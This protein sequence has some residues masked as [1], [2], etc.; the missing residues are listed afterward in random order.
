MYQFPVDM[1][2][3]YESS[4]L[5][6][7][8]YQNI[9]GKAT[10][11]LASD[12][13]CQNTGMRRD[14]VLTWLETGMFERMHPDDVGFMSK[15]SD[16]FL[17]QRGPYDIVFRCR[18]GKDYVSIHGLGKWQTM[19]DG[20]ELA[21]I[22]YANLKQTKEGFFSIAERYEMF[23]RDKF[24]TDPLTELPNINYI[25]EYGDE[26]VNVIRAEGMT[27]TII[28]SDVNSMQSYNNRYGF[29][30]GDK[31]LQLIADSLK[32]QFPDA[33]LTRGADDHFI[34]VVGIK[35]KNDLAAKLEEAND[36]IRESASGNTSGIYS[37]ICIL[38]AGE[39]VVEGIDHAKHALKRIANDM[40]RSYRFFSREAEEEYWNNRYIIENFDRALE[41]GLIKVYYQGL[42]RVESQK[43]AAFEALAR[44]IDPVR[45]TISPGK[46]IPVLQKYHQLYKLDLYMLEQ[47]CKEIHIRHE[48]GLPMLPVSV[49]FSRQDFDHADIVGEMNALYEKYGMEKYVG[50]DY[51]IVE[52]TEQDV[53]VGA[54]TFHDQL[55]RIRANGYQL[56]LD[57][58]GSG[59]SAINM[60]SQFHFDLIKYDMELLRRLDD[61]G[62]ANRLI[63]RELVY[64]AKK[65]G[66]HTLIEGVEN[67]EQIEF[68]REIGCE[69]VQGFYYYRPESLDSQLYRIHGGQKVKPCETIEERKAYNQKWFE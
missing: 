3:S 43:I 19:P 12:G 65:L 7:V 16:D 66:I 18:I 9:D 14:K 28:Y 26:K 58:F 67:E 6:F 44:W 1:R 56:W 32:K 42:I 57:D 33:L 22:G 27:P 63:L 64:V 51:F 38:N 47:V 36:T 30:E 5:S 54:E 68:I 52:I 53:A 62:G 61:N 10:P 35:D 37:G 23:Q 11:I 49:N 15:V 34:I 50:K 60:F 40:T 59:Y 29:K 24:Y 45:G 20:T 39:T 25:H 31:L 21:V 17:H 41:D 55:K 13:F 4:P 48:N 46:F 69:L 2:K 8:Y